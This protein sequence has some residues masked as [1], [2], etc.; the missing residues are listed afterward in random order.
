MIISVKEIRN[1]LI[2]VLIPLVIGYGSNLISSLLSSES[3]ATYYSQLIKPGFAPPSYIFPIVWTILFILMGISAYLVTKKG[4]ELPKVS[5]AMFY[6]K[7]Q[8]GLV[9]L[10]SI[11]FFGLDLRL[12]ALIDLVLLIIVAVVMIVKFYKVD[13]K[14][15]YLNIPYLIWLFYALLLNYFI[16]VINK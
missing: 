9:F 4:Y 11:L 2:S 14:A 5:D 3:M 13:K 16:W 6:Y 15:A 8:L 7:L 12:T 10:W 1:F